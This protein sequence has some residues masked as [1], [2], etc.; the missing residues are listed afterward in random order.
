MSGQGKDEHLHIFVNRKKFGPE[1]GV[2][3]AMTGAQ[4]AGLVG[5]DA[6]NAII[7]EGKADG[8][9][10]PPEKTVAIKNGEHFFVTRKIVD[11]G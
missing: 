9:E 5:V 10:I 8:A 1:D 4:I 3:A 7:R 11:G 2:G 6:D